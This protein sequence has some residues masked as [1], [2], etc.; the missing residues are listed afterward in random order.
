MMMGT[1]RY[2]GFN[3]EKSDN[4]IVLLPKDETSIKSVSLTDEAEETSNKC[5]YF[6]QNCCSFRH[7]YN[8]SVSF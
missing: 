1:D 2:R 4:D 6:N 3:P 8:S 7:D 5:I